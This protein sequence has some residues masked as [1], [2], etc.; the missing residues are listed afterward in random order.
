MTDAGDFHED[1][2]LLSQMEPFPA[3]STNTRDSSA[4]QELTGL[5]S[6]STHVT[7]PPPPQTRTVAASAIASLLSPRPSSRSRSRKTNSRSTASLSPRHSSS[8]STGTRVI[9]HRDAGEV[10]H[11]ADENEPEV[12][13]LPPRYEDS[14][15]SVFLGTVSNETPSSGNSPLPP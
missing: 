1:P 8:I 3:P 7:P 5:T 2:E 14:R 11:E 4:S 9:V 12:V 6:S 13:E 10:I 15:R